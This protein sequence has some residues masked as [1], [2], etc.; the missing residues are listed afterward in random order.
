[1]VSLFVS[2]RYHFLG[3]YVVARVVGGELEAEDDLEA[4]EWLP[5]KGPLPETGFEED[6]VAIEL[7]AKGCMGLPVEGPGGSEEGAIG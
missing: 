2:P 4:V 1:V 7:Q 5:L 6:L 3:V